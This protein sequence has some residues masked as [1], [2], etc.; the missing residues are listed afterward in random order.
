M[1]FNF[2]PCRKGSGRGA[3]EKNDGRHPIMKRSRSVIALLAA[4]AC[5]A[6]MPAHAGTTPDAGAIVQ[7]AFDYARG[8]MSVATV[9]MVI[10]RPDWERSMTLNVWTEGEKNSLFTITAPPKDA[11]NG[12][13]KKGIEMWIYN[14]KVNRAIKLPP[15]MMSQS[16]MGSDF[17]NNDLAKSDT[18]LA[19]YTHTLTGTET[20]DGQT[21]Y[22]IKSM[23]KP[24]APVI[25]GMQTLKIRQDHIFLEETFYDEDFKPVKRLTFYDIGMIG[26]KLYPKKMQMQT[27]DAKDTYTR[28]EYKA[29]AFPDALPDSFFTLSNLVNPGR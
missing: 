6:A 7:A 5:L 9:V 8:K 18:L 13:L 27:V 20:V 14:P 3:D 4:I 11:G 26:G 15:A 24:S 29:L 16:W 28:I 25:W 12:T 2:P 10:H 19:D 22:H 23:P 1:I 21:V 17:S